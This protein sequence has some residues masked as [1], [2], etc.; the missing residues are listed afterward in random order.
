MLKLVVIEN[1]YY[2]TVLFTL[3]ILV[4]N[5]NA[6]IDTIGH[7]MPFLRCDVCGNLY[8]VDTTC[9]VCHKKYM[10]LYK[11]EKSSREENYEKNNNSS[12]NN[13]S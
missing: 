1:I 6:Q 3:L 2:I 5:K 13:I 8:S 11:K 9:Q 7:I 4:F 10:E 12:Q